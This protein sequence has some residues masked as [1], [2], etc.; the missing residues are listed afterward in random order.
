M[1]SEAQINMLL[2]DTAERHNKR[3]RNK[4]AKHEKIA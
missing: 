1:L 4:Q 3:A 2:D